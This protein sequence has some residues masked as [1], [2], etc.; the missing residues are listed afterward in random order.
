MNPN[1]RN[2]LLCAVAFI[3][4]SAFDMPAGFKSTAIALLALGCIFFGYSLATQK[5]Q[6]IVQQKHTSHTGKQEETAQ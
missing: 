2:L 5:K 6:H 4:V 1:L 3:L